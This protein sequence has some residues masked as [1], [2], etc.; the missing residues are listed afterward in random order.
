MS[1]SYEKNQYFADLF[2]RFYKNHLDVSIIFVYKLLKI[3]LFNFWEK[4]FFNRRE[5]KSLWCSCFLKKTLAISD[6]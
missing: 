2:F 4:D 1:S 5:K 6:V 3:I